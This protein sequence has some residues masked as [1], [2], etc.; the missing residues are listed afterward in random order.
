MYSLSKKLLSTKL[1]STNNSKINLILGFNSSENIFY[2]EEFK[3]LGIEPIITTVDGSKG[4][5]G[6]VTDALKNI[7]YTYMYACGP[8]PM[9]KALYNESKTSAQFSFEERMAC[10]FGACM[11]CSHKTKTSYKRICKDGPVLFKEDLAW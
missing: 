3:N 11:A 10:G 8:L 1:L 5:K 7:D 6:F 2:I 4:I 9:L